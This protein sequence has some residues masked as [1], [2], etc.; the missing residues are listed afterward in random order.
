MNKLHGELGQL[1][2]PYSLLHDDIEF[3]L[4]FPDLKKIETDILDE[5]DNIIG[6]NVTY[7][8]R[9]YQTVTEDE[10]EKRVEVWTEYTTEAESLISGIDQVI[11]S[12]NPIDKTA[13]IEIA[14]QECNQRI[15]SGFESDCLGETKH[16][17]CDYTDQSTIQG[18]VIT[19]MLGLQ[20]LTT[21]K[22]EWKAS[23]EL[24]CYEFTYEQ[25]IHLGTDMKTHIQ[26][27]INQFNAER[28]EI[29]NE[30]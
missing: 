4:I 30:Q 11:A 10:T 23:G 25:I 20:G 15:L 29:L 17:D 6:T 16:F 28:M 24:E 5:A 1:S 9:S 8:K 14:R 22:C 21:E 13:A 18:L 3:N 19:A 7:Q 27:N 2:D 26:T 12:H